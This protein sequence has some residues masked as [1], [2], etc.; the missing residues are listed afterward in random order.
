VVGETSTAKSD[1]AAMAKA[2]TAK[3]DEADE[4]TVPTEIERA[5]VEAALTSSRPENQPGGHGEEREVHT[6]SSDEPPPKPHGK[7]VMDAEVSSTAEMAPG[8]TGGAGGRGE[9]GPC[10]L[11]GRSAD[12]PDACLHGQP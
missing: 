6:I 7:A 9:L 5:V 2:T 12:C 4:R 3:V 1:E 8:C 10:S 11:R